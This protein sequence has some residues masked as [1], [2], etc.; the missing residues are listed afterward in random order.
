MNMKSKIVIIG[1]IVF[2]ILACGGC[3][4]S[5]YNK[6]ATMDEAVVNTWAEVENQYQRRSD[7]I[8][9]LVNTVKGYAEH[10][11]S[12]LQSVVEARAAATSVKLDPTNMTQENMAMYQQAQDNLSSALSRLLV[13]VENY[14]NLK[15]DKNFQDLQSQLEGTENRITVARKNFNDATKGY[16]SYIRRFPNNVF[17]NMFGFERKTYFE[18]K[19]GTDVAPEVKF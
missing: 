2:C 10:E 3:V 16:N 19:E 14:P 6:M 12:T 18:A 13:S 8:P 11:S 17:A 1:I 5:S 7:L 4:V 15:A 9:N